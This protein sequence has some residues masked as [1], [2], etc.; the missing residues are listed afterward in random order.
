MQYV[1]KII[2][3]IL[4]FIK[5]QTINR[6]FLGLAVFV[7]MLLVSFG[8]LYIIYAFPS[9]NSEEYKLIIFFAIFIVLVGFILSFTEIYKWIFFILKKILTIFTVCLTIFLILRFCVSILDPFLWTKFDKQSK[10]IQAILLSVT[11]EKYS[12][13]IFYKQSERYEEFLGRSKEIT[14]ERYCISITVDIADHQEILMILLKKEDL[15]Q[16]PTEF[17]VS[18][19]SK[20]E[21]NIIKRVDY[22]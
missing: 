9:I 21:K 4:V 3:E 1:D 13:L 22:N 10:K 14:K 7:I 17:P 19:L 16:F 12:L 5:E 15:N 8:S 18:L 6:N 20:V 11:P 2:K